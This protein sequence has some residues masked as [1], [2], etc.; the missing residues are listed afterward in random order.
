M[1]AGR[2]PWPLKR[3]HKRLLRR[4]GRSPEKVAARDDG[5][6]SPTKTWRLAGDSP[7]RMAGLTGGSDHRRDRRFRTV[8]ICGDSLMNPYTGPEAI[9]KRTCLFTACLQSLRSDSTPLYGGFLNGNPPSYHVS[10]NLSIMNTHRFA[11]RIAL[12]ALC[13]WGM[14]PIAVPVLA[15][16]D[17]GSTYIASNTEKLFLQFSLDGQQL[18]FSEDRRDANDTGGGISARAGWGFSQLFTLYLGLNGARMEGRGNPFVED[19]YDWGAVE[20]GGRFNFRSGKQLVPFADVAL[21]GV[22]AVREDIDLEFLGGGI[23]LGG[24]VAYFVSPAIALEAGFRFGGG[25][26]NEVRVGALSLDIDPDDF[27]YGETRFSFGIVAYPLR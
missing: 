24:G 13:F 11:Q 16:K 27:G 22:A 19:D 20:I 2:H 14:S 10:F 12:V 26:F 5:P 25:G 23:T 3:G 18:I 6:D 1:S 7:D 17:A 9:K 4:S 8:Q 15:Q 21:R